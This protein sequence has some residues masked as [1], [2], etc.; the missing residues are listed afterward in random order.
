MLNLLVHRVTSRLQK[1]NWANSRTCW[2]VFGT[3]PGMFAQPDYAL[4]V[5]YHFNGNL[6]AVLPCM[7]NRLS[8]IFLSGFPPK[9]HLHVFFQQ[10]STAVKTERERERERESVCVCVCVCMCVCVC[11]CACARALNYTLTY[12]RK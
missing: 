7:L 9:T 3:M 11:V 2:D 12:A 1:V 4:S 5:P 8:G 10:S 6:N